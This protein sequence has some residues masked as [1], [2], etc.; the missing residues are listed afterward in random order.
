MMGI[1]GALTLSTIGENLRTTTLPD[2]QRA[3]LD[4]PCDA[5][6][7]PSFIS[8]A[9]S[10]PIYFR[11]H[12]GPLSIKSTVSGN[13][14]YIT[15]G[16]RYIV[17]PDNYVILNDGQRYASEI[18]PD[19]HETESFTIF[20]KPELAEEVL[21]A[22]IEPADMLLDEPGRRP[23]SPITF[24]EGPHRHDNLVSPLLR[25]MHL[26]AETATKGWFEDQFHNLLEAMLFQHRGVVS[27]VVNLPFKKL[28]TRVEIYRRLLRA[29]DYMDDNYRADLRLNDMAREA[30][31]ATHH[32]LRMF[33]E[34]FHV[35]PHQYLTHRR[36]GAA[37]RLLVGTDMSVT[38]ICMDVGF[39]SLGS[40]SSLFSRTVGVSPLAYRKRGGPGI[41]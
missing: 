24:M 13:E 37:R 14:H 30:C 8:H 40:F 2:P 34:A 33:H 7:W 28:S 26:E 3:N 10:G 25:K 21:C 1:V 38:D 17:R 15:G 35:T 5:G 6:Y 18:V 11:E 39:S 16:E 36:L 4:Y 22:M 9:V 29:R 41:V 27:Q 31:M 19:A 32:F 20:F 23:G 12:H